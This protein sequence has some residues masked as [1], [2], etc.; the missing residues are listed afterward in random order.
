MCSLFSFKLPMCSLFSFRLPMR[1]LFSFR[2]PMCSLFPFKLPMCSL[3]SFKLPMCSLFSFKLPMC[4]LFLN[5]SNQIFIYLFFKKKTR[6]TTIILYIIISIR[7][8]QRV[9]HNKTFHNIL[10]NVQFQSFI[11]LFLF[12]LS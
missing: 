5:Q 1:S 4:S 7:Y 3:F 11:I 12:F 8:A 10:H 6:M 2:L 9:V